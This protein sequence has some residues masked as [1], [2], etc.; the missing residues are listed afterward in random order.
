MKKL[1]SLRAKAKKLIN[2][3]TDSTEVLEDLY[4]KDIETL[5]NSV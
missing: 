4:G 1:T 5:A 3:V 2:A